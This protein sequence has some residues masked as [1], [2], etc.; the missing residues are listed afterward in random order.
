MD[1]FPY[2]EHLPVCKIKKQTNAHKT[3]GTIEWCTHF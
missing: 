1:G 3:E 2:C